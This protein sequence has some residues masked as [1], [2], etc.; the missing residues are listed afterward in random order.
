MSKEVNKE[1]PP[2]ADQDGN[3]D[4]THDA[5]TQQASPEKANNEVNETPESAESESS[6]ESDEDWVYDDGKAVG[7]KKGRPP[8]INLDALSKPAL[9]VYNSRDDETILLPPIY[10]LAS[11]GPTPYESNPLKL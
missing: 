8:L 10:P 3:P 11:L 9:T 2:P 5:A 6:S 7:V 4:L 1:T